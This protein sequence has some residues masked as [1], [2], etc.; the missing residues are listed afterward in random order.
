VTEAELALEPVADAPSTGSRITRRGESLVQLAVAAMAVVAG[1]PALRWPSGGLDEMILLVYPL[2]M[3]GGDLPFRDFVATYGP[4]HWW[5]LEAWVGLVGPGVTSLRL[6]GLAQHVLL[7]LGIY[8]LLAPESRRWAT[9][10]A[11]LAEL[12]LV[13]LGDAPY[14]WTS[15]VALCVWQVSFLRATT[16]RRS[17][18]VAGLL[19]G[20]ALGFR[21]D[22]A[23]LA[24]LPALA[25]LR[26][27][28]RVRPWLTGFVV[29]LGPVLV[30]TGLAAKP[31]LDDIFLDRIARGVG[32]TRL[33]L[34]PPLRFEVQLLVVL[35][36][37]IGLAV[38]TALVVRRREWTALAL[39]AV[40]ALPQAFQRSDATHLL[41]A[42]LVSVPMLP[43]V[44]RTLSSQ[45]PRATPTRALLA[46]LT[47]LVLFVAGTE[48]AAER[49]LY[50]TRHGNLA[51]PY[52]TV[53]HDG[54]TVRETVARATAHQ[55]VLRVLD[56]LSTPGE[57]VFVLDQ[58]LT[59]PEFTDVNL[60][61]LLPRLRQTGFNLEI[62]PGVTNSSRSRLAQDVGEADVL[63]LLNVSNATR[64]V[65][66]PY[67]KDGSPLP[68]E[69]L[70]RDFCKRARVHA[71]AI[72]LRCTPRA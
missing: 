16:T 7:C 59:R 42:G 70:A 18:L 67:A 10:S 49:L 55:D 61:Y 17:V 40:L 54:R 36:V 50:I 11:G 47:G 60:Y 33:P 58:D 64:R 29:G 2:R 66:F 43:L 26:G 22:A 45:L 8:R 27:S 68:A 14:A 44:A 48:G 31:L 46:G 63:V 65:Y 21:P 4:T 1:L 69:I 37:A 24:T 13:P 28:G 62:T 39:L 56:R 5:L 12:M 34:W 3:L 38:V 72:Y 41:Y 30:M 19:G 23:L 57:R 15:T 9:V 6:L 53:S 32:Q 25:L 20:L 71:Y 35:V 51:G 52:V